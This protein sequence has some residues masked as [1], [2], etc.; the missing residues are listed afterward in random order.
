MLLKGILWQR[1][2]GRGKL[3]E[4]G[5]SAKGKYVIRSAEGI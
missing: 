3:Y 5:Y 2:K 4:I 1:E